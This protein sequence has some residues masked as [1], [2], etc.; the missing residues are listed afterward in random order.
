MDSFTALQKAIEIVGSEVTSVSRLGTANSVWLCQR[1]TQNLSVIKAFATDSHSREHFQAEAKFLLANQDVNFVP[2]LLH[3]NFEGYF[4]V[5]RFH[6]TDENSQVELRQIFDAIDQN[7]ATLKVPFQVHETLPGILDWWNSGSGPDSPGQRL[8]H[9][10][11]LD[12][13]W[14][15]NA[16]AAIKTGWHFSSVMHGDLKIANLALSQTSFKILDWENVG[17]GNSL[18]DKAGLIQSIFAESLGEGP[19]APWA[20]KQVASSLDLLA[21]SIDQLALCVTARLV[22]TAIELASNA[23]G[24]S[25]YQVNILQM[26]EMLANGN[27]TELGRLEHIA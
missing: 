8:I 21:E 6:K 9:S 24:I 19:L 23:T 22:Q 14:L 27:W 7:F 25:P 4:I 5:T 20:R 26:A 13:D 15:S 11:L 3:A 2:E 12:A 10:L 18:W 17:T 16:L 1:G